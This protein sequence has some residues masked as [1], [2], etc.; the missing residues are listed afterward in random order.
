VCLAAALLLLLLPTAA[1]AAA[2][3]DGCLE[4]ELKDVLLPHAVMCVPHCCCCCC[5]G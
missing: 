3:V 4:S 5:Q 2:R 1:A